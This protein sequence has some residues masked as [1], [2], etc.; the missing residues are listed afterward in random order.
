MVAR[1]SRVTMAVTARR[2]SNAAVQGCAAMVA[3]TSPLTS[4]LLA[5]TSRILWIASLPLAKTAAYI[6]KLNGLGG[7]FLSD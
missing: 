3:N 1:I 2:A 7:V 6:L 5:Q 4:P